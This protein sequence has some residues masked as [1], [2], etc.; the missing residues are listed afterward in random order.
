[1]ELLQAKPKT[2]TLNTKGG[3]PRKYEMPPVIELDA[4][5]SKYTSKQLAKYY[6]VPE[7]TVKY[8]VRYY[9]KQMATASAD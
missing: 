8:W 9:R 7:A 2:Q 4:L 3:R 6:D 1:M 5:Y